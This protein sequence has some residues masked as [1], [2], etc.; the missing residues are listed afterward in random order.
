MQIFVF[1]SW[2]LQKAGPAANEIDVAVYEEFPLITAVSN[3]V[4][5]KGFALSTSQL[6]IGLL[7]RKG[8]GI[9]SISDLEGKKCCSS[10]RNNIIKILLRC[11]K[12][13]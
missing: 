5:L 11:Y 1:M 2:W 6:N 10:T 7:S 9:K 4:D 3:G 12:E 13:K 8:S